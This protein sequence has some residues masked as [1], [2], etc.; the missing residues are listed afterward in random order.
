MLTTFA[1]HLSEPPK[2]FD[3]DAFG[4]LAM[5]YGLIEVDGLTEGFVM[6]LVGLCSFFEL[7][8]RRQRR[9][10]QAA[11]RGERS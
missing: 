1:H 2:L 3:Y 6:G 7:M 9:R 5:S 11:Q 4:L 10:R 8:K